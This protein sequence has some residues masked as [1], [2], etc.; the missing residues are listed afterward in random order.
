MTAK[1]IVSIKEGNSLQ[2]ETEV[3]LEAKGASGFEVEIA[4]RMATVYAENIALAIQCA[5]QSIT[6]EVAEKRGIPAPRVVYQKLG[7]YYACGLDFD[8]SENDLVSD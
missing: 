8:E 3:D 2:V 6:N 1:I 4:K 5:I 7:K